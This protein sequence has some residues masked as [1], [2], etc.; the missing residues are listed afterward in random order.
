ME[1]TV[2]VQIF[3]VSH[4]SFLIVHISDK[5]SDLI[6][7]LERSL[8]KFVKRLKGSELKVN[9]VKTEVCV[10]LLVQTWTII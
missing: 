9:E 1:T 6:G 4:P 7:D 8:D 3:F 2:F 10:F 5:Q